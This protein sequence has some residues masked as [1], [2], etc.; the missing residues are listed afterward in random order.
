[1]PH[2]SP[3]AAPVMLEMGRVGIQ[4]AADDAVL[5]DAARLIAEAMS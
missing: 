2:V 4:G 3:F 5:E 1:L